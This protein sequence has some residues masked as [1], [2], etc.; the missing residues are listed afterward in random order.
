MDLLFSTPLLLNKMI[1]RCRT[2]MKGKW[3][4]LHRA[5]FKRGSRSFL[6]RQFF[7]IFHNLFFHFLLS[8]I[9]VSW[10]FACSQRRLHKCSRTMINRL[11]LY[12]KPVEN[13]IRKFL[14]NALVAKISLHRDSRLRVRFC[15]SARYFKPANQYRNKRARSWLRAVK[16]TTTNNYHRLNHRHPSRFHSD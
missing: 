15:L 11:Y 14:C 7:L 6:M 5:P 13:L 16:I 8:T 2:L 9:R 10:F 12:R 3:L 4:V 1:F